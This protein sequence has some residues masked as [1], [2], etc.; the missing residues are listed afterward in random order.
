MKLEMF[1]TNDVLNRE[2]LRLRLNDQRSPGD[3]LFMMAAEI[4]VPIPVISVDR[5]CYYLCIRLRLLD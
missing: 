1:A 5:I 2:I 3:R 4:E